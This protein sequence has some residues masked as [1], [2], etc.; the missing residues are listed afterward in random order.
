M[1]LIPK[2]QAQG[3]ARKS[4]AR[5]QAI[6]SRLSHG[7][8][9]APGGLGMGSCRGGVIR[10]VEVTVQRA[11]IHVA[12]TFSPCSRNSPCGPTYR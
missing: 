10:A 8:A 9:A 2:A 12:S 11:P 6:S 5:H 4:R 7:T 3:G 1:G